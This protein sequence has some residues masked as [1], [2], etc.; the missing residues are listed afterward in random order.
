MKVGL[1]DID[2]KIPNLAL[3]KLSAYHKHLGHK[4]EMTSP[5]FANQYDL[6]IAS[7]IFDYTEM[8]ILPDGAI[9]GG[10]GT[11]LESKLIEPVE[12]IYPDYSLYSCNYAIGYTSRGCNRRCPF[13]IVPKKE[14][15]G[16][17]LQI[18]T[19][20]GTY[21]ITLCFWITL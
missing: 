11:N 1:V 16:R 15:N 9:V 14:G 19:N 17:L 7:K 18:Y 10:S 12:H 8:P 6:V 13:C 20:S 3:M 4:V 2:S 21:K 5:I